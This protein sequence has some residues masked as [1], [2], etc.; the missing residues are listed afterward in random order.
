MNVIELVELVNKKRREM[1]KE[2]LEEEI[3]R[4]LN[5][6]SELRD[7]IEKLREV[8]TK[9]ILCSEE[10]NEDKK[11]VLQSNDPDYIS[12]MVNLIYQKVNNCYKKIEEERRIKI[13]EQK[14]RIRE[15][16]EKILVYKK[17]FKNIFNENIDV[18]ILSD[19]LE[20]L[21]S[22]IKKGESEIERLNDILKSRVGS[23]LELLVKLIENNEIEID[24]ENLNEVI[25][26]IRFLVNKG[27]I[28]SLRFSK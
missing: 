9:M 19:K 27:L 26:L 11:S 7:S 15:I 16:N 21:D 1:N 12:N 20:D 25:E 2:K 13:E 8:K 6:L 10:I 24:Q 18:Y 5:Q 28:L 22:E 3:R 17:I 4:T 14:R 23:N